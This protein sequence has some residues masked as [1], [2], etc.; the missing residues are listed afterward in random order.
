MITLIKEK[1][2]SKIIIILIILS[3]ALPNFTSLDRIGNQWLYMSLINL[4]SFL[5]IYIKYSGDF[6][7][8]LE[9]VCFGNSVSKKCSFNGGGDTSLEWAPKFA[10]GIKLSEEDLSG[11]YNWRTDAKVA[12]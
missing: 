10:C 1:Q 11:E 3:Y 12:P 2:I 7:F 5:Y 6:S 4:F 8:T 9:N